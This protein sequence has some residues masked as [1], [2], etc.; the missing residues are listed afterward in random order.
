V[1][2]IIEMRK[3][4]DTYHVVLGEVEENPALARTTAISVTEAMKT[5][6]EKDRLSEVLKLAN[7]QVD[8]D[9]SPEVRPKDRAPTETAR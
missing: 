4:K 8:A 9:V 5:M 3:D 1:R 2:E 7:E 6:S